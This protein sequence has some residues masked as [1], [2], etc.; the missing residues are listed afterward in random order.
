MTNTREYA[1]GGGGESYALIIIYLV[2]WMMYFVFKV[3]YLVLGVVDFAF[4]MMSLVFG[5]VYIVLVIN[6]FEGTH[7]EEGNES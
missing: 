1:C 3:V 2:F 6:A 5:M 4:K 7:V